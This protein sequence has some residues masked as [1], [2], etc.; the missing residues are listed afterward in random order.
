MARE[1]LGAAGNAEQQL[2]VEIRLGHQLF[3]NVPVAYVDKEDGYGGMM[4]SEW[5]TQEIGKPI[6]TS[7]KIGL[8]VDDM[9]L[10]MDWLFLEG[11]ALRASWTGEGR[12]PFD[13]CSLARTYPIKKKK[14][15]PCAIQDLPIQKTRMSL[16]CII[17][18]IYAI[19]V[20]PPV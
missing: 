14:K 6:Q 2:S 10:L 7:F 12:E 20:Q 3:S 15:K 11:E 4:L 18:P 19:V 13:S 8:P 17:L 9:N 1:M 5:C 16:F